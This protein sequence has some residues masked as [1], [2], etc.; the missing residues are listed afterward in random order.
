MN[1]RLAV[2]SA[3]IL[4][5]ACV[6]SAAQSRSAVNVELAKVES[7]PLEITIRLPGDLLPYQ[8]VA[9]YSKIAGF[10]ETIVVDRG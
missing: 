5:A 6:Q 3:C 2:V 9:I 4:L 8:S 10:V 1:S 7:R